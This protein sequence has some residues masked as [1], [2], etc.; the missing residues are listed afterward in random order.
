MIPNGFYQDE[1]VGVSG[2]VYTAPANCFLMIG[3]K[4]KNQLQNSN[5]NAYVETQ[6]KHYDVMAGAI[7]YLA[8]SAVIPLAAG[9][10]FNYSYQSNVDTQSF[11]YVFVKHKTIATIIKY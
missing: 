6:G 8:G 10:R 7:T 2:T 4:M 3:T 9:Q 1:T 5:T 11:R